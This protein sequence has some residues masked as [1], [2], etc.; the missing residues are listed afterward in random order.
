MELPG[1]PLRSEVRRPGSN[2]PCVLPLRRGF[3]AV[4]EGVDLCSKLSESDR[5]SLL[6]ALHRHKVL[7]FQT[8]VL[9]SEQHAAFARQFGQL[10]LHPSTERH[11]TILELQK[12]R[13]PSAAKL[14]KIR[15][16]ESAG[17]TIAAG[18]HADTSWRI[19]PAWAG[20]LRAIDVPETGGDTVWV[21]AQGA[22]EQL[23]ETMRA[24]LRGMQVTHD[25]RASLLAAG[26]D[27]PVVAHPLVCRDPSTSKEGVWVNFTAKPRILGLAPDDSRAL[28]RVI[29]H[30]YQDPR[31]QLRVHWKPGTFVFWDNRT[32]VHTATHD[33]GDYPRLLERALLIDDSRIAG[34]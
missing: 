4:I 1:K 2:L 30:Q 3:G 21:D 27:Y 9:N 28:L 7:I 26:I 10:Y 8:Q 11:E 24:G 19:S 14:A 12:I 33:Y 20:V 34:V 6:S 18:F 22:F 17:N 29:L 31:L 16:E 23:P 13:P 5:A 32:T 15:D 25:F